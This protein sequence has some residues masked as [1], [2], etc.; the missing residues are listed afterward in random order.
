MVEQI[1]PNLPQMCP[2]IAAESSYFAALPESVTE[3]YTFGVSVRTTPNL[4]KHIRL[5][6]VCGS[7]VG[8]ATRR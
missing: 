2:S 1:V 7:P 5:P 8:R 6:V 4:K 3:F